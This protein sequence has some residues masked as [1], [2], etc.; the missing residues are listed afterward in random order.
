VPLFCFHRKS[1]RGSGELVCLDFVFERAETFRDLL[2]EICVSRGVKDN[3]NRGTE[4]RRN[5]SKRARELERKEG[6]EDGERD[7][8]DKGG[9][10]C[11]QN[12]GVK[13]GYIPS[14]SW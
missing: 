9:G 13:L 8:G 5:V 12:L 6:G 14:M 7:G 4:W 10:Y 11:L 1:V 3:E 2:S